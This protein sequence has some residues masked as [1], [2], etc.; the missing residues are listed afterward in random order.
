MSFL[1]ID[2]GYDALTQEEYYDL[3]EAQSKQEAR[4]LLLLLLAKLGITRK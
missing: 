3:M 1:D 2:A 4:W